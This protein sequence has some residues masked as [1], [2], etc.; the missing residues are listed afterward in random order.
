MFSTETD[1]S[2]IKLYEEGKFRMTTEDIGLNRN[3]S[4]GIIQGRIV[5]CV[6]VYCTYGSDHLFLWDFGNY[7]YVI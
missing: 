6:C 4:Y 2:N 1:Y 3:W 7:Y 5:V